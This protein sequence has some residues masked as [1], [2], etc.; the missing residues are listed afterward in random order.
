MEEIDGG[1]LGSHATEVDIGRA[2][3]SAALEG[4]DARA[5]RHEEVIGGIARTCFVSVVIERVLWGARVVLRVIQAGR[6]FD[7]RDLQASGRVASALSCIEIEADKGE[8]A[9]CASVIHADVLCAAKVEIGEVCGIRKQVIEHPARL[10]QMPH[11]RG[12]RTSGRNGS[13]VDGG[14]GAVEANSVGRHGVSARS[15]TSVGTRSAICA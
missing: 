7:R 9:A 14:L 5:R 15:A 10:N 1:G 8:G 4:A 2:G 12:G 6:C 13:P 11:G 3:S